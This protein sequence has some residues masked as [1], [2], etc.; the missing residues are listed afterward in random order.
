MNDNSRSLTPPS[1]DNSAYNNDSALFEAKFSLKGSNTHH[2]Y[3]S[4]ESIDNL[5]T[6]MLKQTGGSPTIECAN[7]HSHV[8]RPI[9]WL[10]FAI[11]IFAGIVTSWCSWSNSTKDWYQNLDGPNWVLPINLYPLGFFLFYII[12]SYIVYQGF[13]LAE[14]QFARNILNLAFIVQIILATVFGLV[15]FCAR[16]IGWAIVLASL[17]LIALLFLMW[18]LYMI[19]NELAFAQ[20]PYLIWSI[21]LLWTSIGLATD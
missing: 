5:S 11:A 18:A 2:D 21:F 13:Q 7:N 8:I 12:N 4:Y 6:N 16:S 1:Y 17:S 19:K 15:L 10:Y 3:D 20:L 9:F 14:T